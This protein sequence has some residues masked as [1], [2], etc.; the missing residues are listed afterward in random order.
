MGGRHTFTTLRVRRLCGSFHPSS[1]HS[2]TVRLMLPVASGHCVPNF[3]IQIDRFSMVC[4]VGGGGGGGDNSLSESMMMAAVE[5]AAAEEEQTVVAADTTT[6]DFVLMVQKNELVP[7][8]RKVT[9]KVQTHAPK[10]SQIH[11]L[12]CCRS[13]QRTSLERNL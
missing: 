7:T 6:R 9:A 11:S 13:L 8:N 5:V 10:N 3:W 2:P 12:W 4:A 1:S